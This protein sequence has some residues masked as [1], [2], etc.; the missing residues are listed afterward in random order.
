MNLPTS[1]ERALEALL[2]SLFIDREFRRFLGRFPQADELLS[3]LPSTP[4]SLAVLIENAIAMLKRHGLVDH[5]FFAA[6]V[7][8]RPR[9]REDIEAV[10]LLWTSVPTQQLAV[11][12]RKSRTPS[13]ARSLHQLLSMTKVDTSSSKNYLTRPIRRLM[14]LCF[15]DLTDERHQDML[16]ACYV[17]SSATDTHL[18]ELEPFS[19]STLPSALRDGDEVDPVDRTSVD[20]VDA[21]FHGEPRKGVSLVVGPPGSGKSTFFAMLKLQV[22]RRPEE[23][24]AIYLHVDLINNTQ[25][26][27]S[28]FDHDRLID[29]ICKDLLDQAETHYSKMSPFQNSVLR[30]VFAGELRRFRSAR[31]P[32]SPPPSPQDEDEIILK[33]LDRRKEHLK[34]WLGFV[35]REVGSA[36]VVLDNVD[37]GTVAFEKVIYQLAADLAHKTDASI[38]ISMRGTTFERGVT[39]GFLDVRLPTVLQIDPPPFAEV[40]TARV[41]YIR[42]ELRG[43]KHLGA[44]FV[45]DMR[46]FD[47]ERV[48]DFVEILAGTVLNRPPAR[49]CI[50]ALGGGNIREALKLVE[51]YSTSAHTDIN[52]LFRDYDASQGRGWSSPITLDSF[53]RSVMKGENWVYN[54]ARAPIVNLLRGAKNTM[55]ARFASVRVLQY[56]DWASQNASCMTDA[57]VSAIVDTMKQIGYEPGVVE[58]TVNFLGRERLIVSYDRLEAPW[59]SEDR[60]RIGSSGRYYIHEILRSREY[61]LACSFDILLYS[62]K[63]AVSLER[64]YRRSSTKGWRKAENVARR[65]A[66]MLAEEERKELRTIATHGESPVWILPVMPGIRSRFS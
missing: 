14:R 42:N 19:A 29:A 6:L 38:A 35:A 49:E 44:Q 54:E 47:H 46:G 25:L 20:P 28:N 4:A 48:L 57:S 16:R 23:H 63:D 12:E 39:G 1:K 56:L 65:C 18:A 11:A 24:K 51:R 41:E 36:I 10:A 58:R 31:S 53:L 66:D 30:K 22:E 34:A 9:R 8:E 21:I 26:H 59:A 17:R 61:F 43:D 15:H 2:Q 37:Q 27:S 7:G 52:K 33:H 45:R 60:V 62:E 3:S 32:D 5:E 40:A 55:E 50:S 13:Y 64:V